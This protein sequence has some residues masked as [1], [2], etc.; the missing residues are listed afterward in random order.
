MLLAALFIIAKMETTPV[1][2]SWW[3]EK[4]IVV[5]LVNGILF[6]N[7]VDKPLQHYA[8]WRPDAKGHILYDAFNMKSPE[9][10]NTQR[11]KEIGSC[12]GPGMGM[13]EWLQTNMRDFLGR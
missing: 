10:V 6:S 5:Y 1:S 7:T 13:R 8:K 12:V 4:Q 3:V 9:K 11:Q 2:T